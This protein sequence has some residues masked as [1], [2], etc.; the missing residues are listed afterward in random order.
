[1]LVV[2][3]MLFVP[4]VFAIDR[5]DI[6]LPNNKFGIHLAVPSR[7]DEQ[8]AAK[9]VNSHGGSWGYVTLVIQDNDRNRKAQYTRSPA[10]TNRKI[11]AATR[12]I[13]TAENEFTAC[14]DTTT[15]SGSVAPK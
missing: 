11:H 5:G 1:M 13:L 7:E 15:S 9:L 4:H 6:S 10:M 3:G 12:R 2:L 8:S 14:P